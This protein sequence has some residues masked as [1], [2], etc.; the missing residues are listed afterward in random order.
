MEAAA[1]VLFLWAESVSGD[2]GVFVP[3][4]S[5]P[6]IFG[7]VPGTLREAEARD[8]QALVDLRALMFKSM[9]SPGVDSVSWRTQALI[10]FTEAIDSRDV[11]IA[12]VEDDDG[13]I[14]SC[15]MGQVRVQAPSPTNGSGLVGQISNIVTIPSARRR[16]YAQ[17]C[18]HYVVDW[19]RQETAVEGLELFATD[20]GREM[21]AAKGFSVHRYP[22]MRMP[23]SR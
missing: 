6:M 18:F 14:S 7:P 3:G 16:G 19:F 21:Y 11:C 1:G 2:P 5:G 4:I 17:A 15:A 22:S 9:G 12:V 13:A 8:A 10:W 20:D 23:L